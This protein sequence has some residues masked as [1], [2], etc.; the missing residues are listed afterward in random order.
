M[1]GVIIDPG[2]KVNTLRPKQNGRHI[3]D[4]IFKYIFLNENDY[5]SVKISLKSIP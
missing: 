2:I 3:S 4:D 1:R 5:I